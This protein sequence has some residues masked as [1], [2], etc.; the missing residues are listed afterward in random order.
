MARV[1]GRINYALCACPAELPANS[2]KAQQQSKALPAYLSGSSFFCSFLIFH[3][4]V[5]AAWLKWPA[6][7]FPDRASGHARSPVNL[8]LLV[9]SLLCVYACAA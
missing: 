3:C 7:E 4:F 5:C 1:T 2:E 8:F 9:K 6:P